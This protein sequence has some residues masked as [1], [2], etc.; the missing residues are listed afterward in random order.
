MTVPDIPAADSLRADTDQALARGREILAAWDK[1]PS[2]AIARVTAQT[3][4]D[5]LN[6]EFPGQHPGRVLA[7]AVTGI[8]SAGAVMAQD[9][10]SEPD[11][12]VLMTLATVAA[13]L[14]EDAE[15]AL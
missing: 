12:V 13:V 3:L 7:S 4:A 10:G 14:A 5:M 11:S 1:R 15:A 8:A 6:A 2:L 9:T